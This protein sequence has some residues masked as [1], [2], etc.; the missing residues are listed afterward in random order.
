MYDMPADQRVNI[1]MLAMIKGESDPKRGRIEDA[2]RVRVR[3]L[4]LNE[5]TAGVDIEKTE[6]RSPRSGR[7]CDNCIALSYVRNN[8]ESY[9][10]H[11]YVS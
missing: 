3:G 2:F 11:L 5:K 1:T 7:G 4:P 9:T 10:H 8:E 6:G